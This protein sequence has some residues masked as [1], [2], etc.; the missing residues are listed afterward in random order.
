MADF[1]DFAKPWVKA[2]WEV[3]G[4]G[5]L[6]EDGFAQGGYLGLMAN[7]TLPVLPSPPSPSSP[8]SYDLSWRNEAGEPCSIAALPF[9]GDRL[10]SSSSRHQVRFGTREPIDCEI[11]FTVRDDGK[12]QGDLIAVPQGGMEGNTGTVTAEPQQPPAEPPK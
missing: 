3:R 5:P 11:V 9:Q 8:G 2:R 7:L 12:L 6:P 4:T 10:R 1:E